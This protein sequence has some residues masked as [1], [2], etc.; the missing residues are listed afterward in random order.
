MIEP[1][2]FEIDLGESYLRNRPENWK[3]T[4]KSIA[5]RWALIGLLTPLLP[6]LGSPIVPVDH[7]RLSGGVPSNV[8]QVA[9][10]G[11][12]D[13]RQTVS[14]Y[15]KSHA[16]EPAELRKRVAATGEINCDGYRGSANLTDQQDSSRQLFT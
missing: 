8:H 16:I 15:A 7:N 3:M 11:D 12:V 10:Y 13:R 2:R 9:V 4:N 5:I 14:E 6:A 1:K